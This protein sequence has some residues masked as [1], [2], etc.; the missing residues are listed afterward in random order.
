MPTRVVEVPPVRVE[1][2]SPLVL[3]LERTQAIRYLGNH[4]RYN[5]CPIVPF[6]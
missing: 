2:L 6:V 5:Q 3:V 1:L 4:Q